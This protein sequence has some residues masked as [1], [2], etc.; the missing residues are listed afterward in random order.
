[1]Q[2]ST[3]FIAKQITKQTNSRPIVGITLEIRIKQRSVFGKFAE[4]I[5][6]TIIN[7]IIITKYFAKYLG[8]YVWGICL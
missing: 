7:L 4:F 6:P 1:M 3:S 8:C 5:H 2:S